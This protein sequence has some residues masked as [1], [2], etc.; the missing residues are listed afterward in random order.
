MGPG[1]QALPCARP[2]PTRKDPSVSGRLGCDSSRF[3]LWLIVTPQPT[4][5]VEAWSQHLDLTPISSSE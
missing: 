3:T 1:S 2:S 5:R 4:D